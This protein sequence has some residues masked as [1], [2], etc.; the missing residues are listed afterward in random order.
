MGQE[1]IASQKVGLERDSGCPTRH[2]QS[3]GPPSLSLR[4]KNDN[5]VKLSRS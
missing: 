3:C 1:E 4:T 2:L 5:E